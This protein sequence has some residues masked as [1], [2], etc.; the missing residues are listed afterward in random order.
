MHNYHNFPGASLL[1][2]ARAAA[3]RLFCISDTP[4]DAS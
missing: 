1:V 3:K 2:A 4:K